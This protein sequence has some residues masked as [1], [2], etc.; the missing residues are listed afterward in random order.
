L[1]VKRR[2][3]LSGA[4]ALLLAGS[5]LADV[6]KYPFLFDPNLAKNPAQVTQD[7][8]QGEANL[9]PLPVS[10]LQSTNIENGTMTLWFWPESLELLKN[11]SNAGPGPM[12]WP[13][14]PAMCAKHAAF[15]IPTL[16]PPNAGPDCVNADASIRRDLADVSAC[17]LVEQPELYVLGYSPAAVRNDMGSIEDMVGVAGEAIFHAGLPPAGL[18]PSSFVP[19]MRVILDKIRHDK[20]A[21]Q[22]ESAKSAYA[23]ALGVANAN[24]ACFVPAALSQLVSDLGNLTGELTAATAY[25]DKLKA[26]GTAASAHEATCLAGHSRTRNALPLPSLTADE[27]KFLAFWLGGIFWRMRGG[28]LIPL[29]KTQDARYY[30]VDQAFSQIGAVL[31]AQDG[32]DTAFPLFTQIIV[33]GWSQWMCMGQC[34]G[35]LDKYASLVGMTGRGQ[36][37]AQAAIGA[38]NSRGYAL[39]DLLTGGLQMGPGYYYGWFVLRNFTYG[40]AM[41]APYSAFIDGPTSVGEF[42]IGA[43]LE[44]GVARSLLAGKAT[45]QP[46]TVNLCA[47]RQCGDDTCG[48]SCGTCAPGLACE[49]GRCV[50]GGDAGST[51]PDAAS[52][53]A[54]AGAP[55]GGPGGGAGA[56]DEPANARN[57]HGCG[58]TLVAQ[59][60]AS[61]WL[62]AF[63]ALFAACL[64]RARRRARAER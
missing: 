4:G 39:G 8:T 18:L 43:S 37:L 15:T 31:G 58:C 11:A 54:E 42:N 48:G 50:A 21:S 29:G 12:T 59:K 41:S 44:L 52:A 5:A 19:T 3:L 10:E 27:R 1:T 33:E 63:L 9:P 20:L 64:R 57:A 51:A 56:T 28:G 53:G 7:I 26:D 2:F 45:G 47:G 61:S 38:I 25:L 14:T 6:Q 32:T 17:V 34:G 16:L 30:Y 40:T 36:R 49:D 60:Q 24:A 23:Q 22:L 46:P 35:D 13:S 62:A 55:R